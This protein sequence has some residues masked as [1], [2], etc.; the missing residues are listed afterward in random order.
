MARNNYFAALD[1][2]GSI[3]AYGQ[4][5]GI[6]QQ[7]RQAKLQ[8]EAMRQRN[9]LAEMEMGQQQQFNALA[10]DPG[11]TPEQFARAGRSD[12]ANSIENLRRGSTA[13]EAQQRIEEAKQKVLKA[14]YALQSPSPMVQA[15]ARKEIEQWGPIAGIGPAAPEKPESFTLS[16]GQKRFGPNGEQVAGIDPRPDKPT[17]RWRTLTPE[18]ITSA[19]L[20][21]GSSA[22][23]NLETGQ[24]NPLGKRDTTGSLSQKDQTTAK[25]KLNM[26]QN[27][28]Q[29]LDRIKQTFEAGR[30][31]VNAFG[32]GQGI[33]PTQ[34]G[35]LFDAAVDQM[36]SSL[37]ALTRTPGVG[38]MSDY[39]TRL[40]Q[41]KFPARTDYETVTAQKL[42]GI[43]DFLNTVEQGYT[44]M[45]A[46]PSA[47]APRNV[48]A[49][50]GPAKVSSPQE[51][52]RLPPGTQFV[53]PDGRLKVRP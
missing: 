15:A 52:M 21:P 5:S 7:Q 16:P 33:L 49:G 28:R 29:Q 6:L 43:E 12:V 38:A 8:Q 34:A 4:M 11:T 26:V 51:A 27:A 17:A 42:Q 25:L 30:Q 32:P 18:E 46:G 44:D 13:Q 23:I 39:E 31:G 47:S 2:R 48:G 40:D 24:I 41:S 20:P 53:T 50:G 22:Q 35:K 36:R 9:M 19:G 3:P 1:A 14:Q 37:T 10:Q 45:L